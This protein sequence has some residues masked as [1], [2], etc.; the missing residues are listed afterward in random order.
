MLANDV[1]LAND[2]GVNTSVNAS[3]DEW[4]VLLQLLPR[5]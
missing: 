2:N 1:N 4:R 5:C 3:P